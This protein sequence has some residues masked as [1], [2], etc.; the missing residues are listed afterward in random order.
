MRCCTKY[1]EHHRVHAVNA[2]EYGRIQLNAAPLGMQLLRQSASAHAG[3]VAERV[4]HT[5]SLDTNLSA[6]GDR[7]AE[8][9]L[10]DAGRLPRDA[11]RAHDAHARFRARYVGLTALSGNPFKCSVNL[12]SNGTLVA[13]EEAGELAS[14]RTQDLNARAWNLPPNL[15][16]RDQREKEITHSGS[17]GRQDS[18]VLGRPSAALQI[19]VILNILC[20]ILRLYP[21]VDC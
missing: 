10:G 15:S 3:L 21:E 2:A 8:S 16:E 6:S 7:L 18:H 4:W 17:Q 5:F 19:K 14:L 13:W 20:S 1:Q 12:C 11:S 9:P